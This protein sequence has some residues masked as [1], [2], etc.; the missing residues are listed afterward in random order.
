M[1]ILFWSLIALILFTYFGYPVSLLMLNKLGIGA[2]KVSNTITELP[3]M[4]FVVAAY[5]EASCIREKIENTLQLDYDWDKLQLVVVADGSNDHTPEIVR[6]YPGVTLYHQPERQG[7]VAAINRVMPFLDS[8]VIVL[9][10]ANTLLNTEAL[11]EMGQVFL[12]EKVGAVSGEKVVISD[13]SDDATASEGLY[14][15]YESAIKKWDSELNTMVGCAGELMSFRKSL[16]QPIEED[17]YIEDFVMSMRIAA[18]GHKVAYCPQAKAHELPSASIGDE[19][20]RKVRIAAGGLQAIWRLRGLLNPFRYGL[21]TY[22]YVG[23]RVLR[24]T[25]TPLSLPFIFMLNVALMEN[26]WIYGSLLY[27]QIA[28][29]G[30]ALLGS[31]FKQKKLTIKGLFVPYYFTMMNYAVFLG[32]MRLLKGRQQ[33]TWEKAER[34]LSASV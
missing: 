11:E 20:K 33:V 24:W 34:R 15:K 8:E 19:M 3:T 16:Y 32:F 5:N 28:F 23:H 21:L 10:D 26:S 6:Q 29:Y 25:L 18:D 14:W 13:G 7:K 12:N 27:T 30:I 4:T 22:Q 31:Y 2:P 17:T 1:Q 9:S